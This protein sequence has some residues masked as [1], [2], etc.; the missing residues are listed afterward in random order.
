MHY[1]THWTNASA[2][3]LPVEYL[4]T[5]SFKNDI[6]KKMGFTR[7]VLVL[8][9][10]VILSEALL[11]QSMLSSD[12][13][14]QN[15]GMAI[16]SY[17]KKD[18]TKFWLGTK[19]ETA[20]NEG[21][22]QQVGSLYL[23]YAMTDWLE[24]VA[25]VPYINNVSGNDVVKA[26]GLQDISLFL[27]ARLWERKGFTLG[28]GAGTQIAS[29]YNAG[30]L[31]SIGNGSTSFD[32]LLIANYKLKF[33]LGASAQAGFSDRSNGVPDARL[34]VGKLS[35]AHAKF[36]IDAA[37]GIQRS[38]NGVDIGGAGFTGES[39][40]PRARVNYD[41]LTLSAY[42]PIGNHFG[43]TANFGQ[44]LSGRNMGQGTYFGGGVA[45]RF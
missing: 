20:P 44:V 6:M 4:S 3:M 43:I 42:V 25:N 38:K 32:G 34:F 10:S 31:Y 2:E 9:A 7:I 36:Y 5:F 18:Y 26:K 8:F 17:L 22:S 16:V 27:K 14:K 28:L 15:E 23:R 35:Y 40:F 19:E 37:Y 11:A 39:D 41:Q 33:G 1:S 13:N 30:A 24:G 45:Y 29:D 12:F 21:L